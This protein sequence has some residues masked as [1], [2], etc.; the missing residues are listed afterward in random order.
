MQI[1]VHF[2]YMSND[3]TSFPRFPWVNLMVQKR[4]QKKVR[5]KDIEEYVVKL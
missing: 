2:L 3:N 4:L 5:K 1:G